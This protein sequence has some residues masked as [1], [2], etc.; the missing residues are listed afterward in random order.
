M[1][2]LS[3]LE[4]TLNM[5]QGRY[6]EAESLYE[7]A[8]S[9]NR[10][11]LGEFHPRIASN[12]NNLA[13]SHV[14]Q[15]RSDIATE[16]IRQALDIEERN[17][18]TNL[19]V[20]A[21]AQRQFY[22]AT[23]LTTSN[24]I[25]SFS[26]QFPDPALE[27]IALTTLLRR[28]GRLLEVG[29]SSMQ[30]LRKNLGVEDRQNFDAL[31]IAQQQLA[32]FTFNR[33]PELSPE[34][35]R[36]RIAELENKINALETI[37]ARRSASFRTQIQPVDI[38]SVQ[39]ALPA[40]SVLLEYVRYSPFYATNTDESWGA[41]RYGVYLLFPDGHIRSFDLGEAATI[42][43]AVLALTRNLK[44]QHVGVDILQQQSR[45]LYESLLAP[46]ES[47]L[48][49]VQRLLISP[50]SNLSVLPFEVLRPDNEKYL[51]ESYSIS[52]L[53]SGR[54]LTQ[55]GIATVSDNPA[56][57]LAAPSYGRYIATSDKAES[58]SSKSSDD[59]RSA[60]LQSLT[61][62][63]LEWALREGELIESLIPGSIL[64]VGAEANE[65][66]IKEMATPS[67]L[68]IATHGIFLP[69]I[70]V[71]D[72]VETESTRPYPLSVKNPLLRSMLAFADFNSRGREDS[73]NDGVF[74]ALE[75]SSLNLYGTQL[76]TLSACDTGTGEVANWEGVYG[77]RRSFSMA[78]AESLL[79]SLWQVD[80][81]STAQLMERYYEKL[82][83]GEER[84]E[85]LR[86]LQIEMIHS[87]EYE[88]SH[89]NQ[90]AA[91]ILTGN[92]RPL[93]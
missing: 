7:Q 83:E 5:K 72:V 84:G 81:E 76:V 41:S 64:K 52:Y 26:F 68:H 70:G 42:D 40:D 85:A 32:A 3:L 74:T 16:L 30:A 46:I 44:D 69:N 71:Q 60:D 61:V 2:G 24:I 50:E 19:S 20:L 9:I 47:E 35:Y 58:M 39:A 57:I 27:H 82:L 29:S 10:E 55:M 89:P 8:T 78:G 59:S 49:G 45:T 23:A 54:E 33:P 86:Q 73:Q 6:E 15:G 31:V 48:D 43:Q 63:P 1:M 25:A 34:D 12:L 93:R 37:L 79:I 62:S 53:N 22:A 66:F 56:V 75:A 38:P 28:K 21:E 77:L 90:W 80:D 65:T 17:L 11:Q 18:D 51:V 14:A 87:E 67:I 4:I 92:W 91:F 88:V 36:T 13:I